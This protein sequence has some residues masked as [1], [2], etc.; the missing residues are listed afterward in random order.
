[1]PNYWAVV[2]IA[3]GPTLADITID[4]TFVPIGTSSTGGLGGHRV[5]N[6]NAD[7]IPFVFHARGPKSFPV[8]LGIVLSPL[9]SGPDI[10][11][12]PPAYKIPQSGILSVTNGQIPI[13]NAATANV[14]PPP[15]VASAAVTKT[16]AKKGGNGK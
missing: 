1:M 9:P 15:A 3:A 5:I 8:T 14:Q 12:N 11:F 7:P 10:K 4:G 2:T 13:K 16:A 6:S